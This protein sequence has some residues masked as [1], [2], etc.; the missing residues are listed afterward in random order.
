MDNSLLTILILMII[1]IVYEA[2]II[3]AL[4][5]NRKKNIDLIYLIK[6]L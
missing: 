4:A 1:I 6:I 5:T 3:F 2:G